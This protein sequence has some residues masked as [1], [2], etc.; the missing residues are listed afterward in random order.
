MNSELDLDKYHYYKL[1]IN[2]RDYSSYQY[3]P[4]TDDQPSN[5][6]FAV[7]PI[8][9]HFFHDDIIAFANDIPP[10]I[11]SRNIH[12]PLLAKS[13]VRTNI[14]QQNIPGILVLNNNQ[15]YGRQGKKH[16]YKCIPHDRRLPIFL[17]PHDDKSIAHFSKVKINKYITF[18]FTEWTSKHPIGMIKVMIGDVTQP[19]NIYSYLLACHGLTASYRTLSSRIQTILKSYPKDDD[20]NNLIDHLYHEHHLPKKIRDDSSDNNNIYTIDP[21]DCVDNDDAF[22]IINSDKEEWRITV[23][24]SNV[25][26]MIDALQLWDVFPDN[27]VSTIYMPQPTGKIGMLPPLVA[28]GLF[29]LRANHRRFTMYMDFSVNRKSGLI[30]KIHFGM[31]LVFI[32][33]NLVYD[34][35]E[36]L[37][38]PDYIQL[39]TALKLA[40]RNDSLMPDGINDCHDVVAYLMMLMNRESAQ[41]LVHQFGKGVLRPI[42]RPTSVVP[43][44]QCDDRGVVQLYHAWSTTDSF[45]SRYTT[46]D[47]YIFTGFDHIV[48]IN[49]H[50]N[51]H[52][53]GEMMLYCHITSPIRRLPDLL[54]Q[55]VFFEGDFSTQAGLFYEKWMPHIDGKL[56]EKMRHVKRV[57][58]TAAT[59]DLF[60]HREEEEGENT[61]KGYVMDFSSS[62]SGY[63]VLQI[64]IPSL[65]L[66]TPVKS[67]N[68]FPPTLC[69]PLQAVD[70]RVFSFMDEDRMDRKFRAEI[71]SL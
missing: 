50:D 28:D 3:D 47:N 38:N 29:S 67:L 63:H 54:N 37:S 56:N 2:K 49:D 5:I 4:L 70:I 22:R 36:L 61:Y 13:P 44:S 17:I 48:R 31:A 59:V 65:K 57:Q 58:N 19:P 42:L 43:T 52:V 62:S 30:S 24:I 35:P 33:Q 66:M 25:A 8:S 23:Y 64:Y 34:T 69:C 46:V 32:K 53:E 21:A 7:N 20:D 9:Y 10:D 45:K 51:D 68:P 15:V 60:F 26:F 6:P 55:I 11:Q 14:T 39:E 27:K 71:I 1:S 12:F 18:Q 40:C 41:H 16:L